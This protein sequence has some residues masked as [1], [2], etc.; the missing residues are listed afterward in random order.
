VSE[1]RELL[2]TPYPQLERVALAIAHDEY[3]ALDERWVFGELDRLA[4]ALGRQLPAG[5]S[6]PE[7]IDALRSVLY[8]EVGFACGDDEPEEPRHSYLNE[9]LQRRRGTTTLLGVLLLTVGAR[10]GLRLE[11]VGFPGHLLVRAGGALGSYLDPGDR[12]RQLDRRALEQLHFRI[13][14]HRRFEEGFLRAVGARDVALRMLLDL[15]RAHLRRRDH[16]RGMLVCDRLVDLTKAP[17][18]M[19]DR[20]I[21]AYALGAYQVAVDDLVAYLTDRPNEADAG[22][23]RR[24][25]EQALAHALDPKH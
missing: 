5:A 8:D 22:R 18:H 12:A 24:L 3:A 9:V 10:V 13:S 6:V 14:G 17:E 19:R 11:A 15:K 7:R 20:G 25:L 1:L 16:A 21:H 2:I 23:V 4:G